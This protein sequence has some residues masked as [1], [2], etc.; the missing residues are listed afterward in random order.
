MLKEHLD[1]WLAIKGDETELISFPDTNYARQ[2][3]SD[4]HRHSCGKGR[5]K[6]QSGISRPLSKQM[7]FKKMDL[8]EPLLSLLQDWQRTSY[9]KL[10]KKKA[11]KKR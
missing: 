10:Y 4:Y 5:E 7:N 3:I 6:V 8:A 2:Q 1:T 9:D 11:A